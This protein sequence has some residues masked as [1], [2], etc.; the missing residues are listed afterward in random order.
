MLLTALLLATMRL[1]AQDARVVV[2]D[3]STREPVARA[4][5]YAKENGQFR[6]AI[7]NEL[8]WRVWISLSTD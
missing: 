8:G 6:A 4:S 7:S 3:A 2:A 5:L 1:S